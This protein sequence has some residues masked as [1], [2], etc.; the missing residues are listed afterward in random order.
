MEYRESLVDI[1]RASLLKNKA[2]REAGK[3]ISIP[4]P[5]P[6]MAKFFPG[7]QKGRYFNITANSKIGKTQIT[8]F[9]F[10]YY[11]FLLKEFSN[12]NIKPKVHYFSLEM[13]KEDKIKQ[14]MA[15]FIYFFKGKRLSSDKLDSLFDDYILGNDVV[16]DLDDIDPILRRFQDYVTFYD[17]IAN[18]FG[19]YKQMRD[20]A[21]SHGHYVDKDGNVLSLE[22]IKSDE[23]EQL[24]IF[25]YIPDDEDE[26]NIVIIDHASLITPE[27]EDEKAKNPLHNAMSRLSNKYLMRMRDRWKYIPVLV[28]QQAQAQE[29]VE[30][31]KLGQLRPS[32]NG[33]A[34][35][36][37][38]GR[39]CDVMMGLFAPARY[40]IT[41][42]L[43]Y[44]IRKLGDNHR[45]LLI[46]LNRRGNAVATQLYFD[47][48]VN[49]FR[50]LPEASMMT[51][52]TYDNIKKNNVIREIYGI[53][54]ELIKIKRNE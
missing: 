24:K 11:P 13:S 21:N 48:A 18:P 10:L 44:D 52:E 23:K 50:E 27:K 3:Q 14:A 17:N 2:D 12:T 34:D 43:G 4:N 6:R 51:A 49:Y 16:N 8:D 1:V 38:L 5:F 30:N 54:P 15:F 32:H 45:E 53:K 42:H 31:M 25:R 7:I 39:D 19:I 9:L 29:G 46:I 37:L 35:N 26:Y 20:Y 40:N 28:Q 47:G 33:L 22:K 41:E 36:K